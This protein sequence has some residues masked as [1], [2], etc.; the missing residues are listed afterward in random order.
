MWHAER[1][2]QLRP[3]RCI[4]YTAATLDG[5]L[6]DEHHDL[7]WLLRLTPDPE[8][9]PAAFDFA[10]FFGDVGA[11]VMGANTY[12]WVY[13]HED[14][15]THPERWT[16]TYGVVPTWV[17]THGE[18]PEVDGADIRTVRGPVADALP[19][20][21]ETAG[22]G[23]IWLLGGGE[24]AGQVDDAGALDELRVSIAPV[25]LGHGKPLLP[26]RLVGR[27][28]TTG[29]HSDGTFAYLSYDVRPPSASLRL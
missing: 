29:V 21:R 8:R 14:L 6:A 20:I 15:A 3:P 22:E 27:L 4:Y 28:T 24:L 25:T 5:F 2:A 7:D 9:T 11:M 18:L 17:F 1:M 16:D 23:D 10:S 12:R 19:A 26:R 13:R